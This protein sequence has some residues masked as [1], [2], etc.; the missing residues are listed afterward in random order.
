MRRESKGRMIH[1]SGHGCKPRT[2]RRGV[3]RLATAL[4]VSLACQAAHAQDT[5]YWSIQNGAQATLLGGT[6]VAL[7]PDLSAAYYNPGSLVRGQ[8]AGALSMFA[9]TVTTL[10]LS[11][12]TSTPLDA[13]SSIGASAPGMFAARIPGVHIVDGDVIAFSYLVHQSSKLDLGGAVLSSPVV[14]AEA[15]DFFVFQDIYDGWYGLSWARDVN[16]LGV[17]V[18]L[19]LSSVSYR[20][21]IETKNSVISLSQAGVLSEN[22]Y[23]SFAARR[24]VAKGGI[25]WSGGPV[26][27]G[28]TVSLPTMGLPWSS[29]TVSV[30]R[31]LVSIDSTLVAQIATSRQEDLDAD[32][33]E[34]LS[35]ALGAQLDAGSFSFHASAE[36]FASVNEYDVLKTRPLESQ[37]PP[38]EIPLPIAQSRDAVFNVGAGV[39]VQTTSWLSFFGSA[40]TD[41]SYRNRDQRSFVGLDGYDIYHVTA[42]IGLAKEDFEIILGGLWASG[43]ADGQVVLSPLPDAPAVPSH[44]EFEQRGFVLAFNASF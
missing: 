39:A 23:Y 40:R 16:G 21:R 29:G 33:R 6:V 20:Q 35:I 44:T 27:L 14:P 3:I 42:G 37:V 7:D 19:Y 11:L 26:S 12:R 1:D 2:G 43:D 28:A 25:T 9:K 41:R 38:A 34:P 15:L 30:G 17:G 36:W 13:E 4:F 22:L 5:H 10:N 31:N 8:E 24:I 18:S 32:Y